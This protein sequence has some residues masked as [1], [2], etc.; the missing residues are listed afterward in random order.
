MTVKQIPPPTPSK[1]IFDNSNNLFNHK[2]LE[3]LICDIERLNKLHNI[4]QRKP[5]TTFLNVLS[6]ILKKSFKL[7]IKQ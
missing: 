6:Q 3:V 2:Y 7:N 5:L 4:S 1:I